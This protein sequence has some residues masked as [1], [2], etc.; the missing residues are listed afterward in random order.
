MQ[1]RERDEAPEASE[2]VWLSLLT[3]FYRLLDS[4]D[5]ESLSA[6]MADEFLWRRQGIDLRSRFDIR[7]ALS[8]RRHDSHLFHIL[9][10]VVFETVDPVRVRYTG[11][12][13]VLRAQADRPDAIRVAPSG[14]QS[15][16][17]CEGELGLRD[18]CWR[19]AAMDAG[20]PRL[21]INLEETIR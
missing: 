13:V 18:G 7:A 14:A 11:Y 12:L 16:H 4:G 20:A 21:L 5:V 10:S 3:R 15:L 2:S 1:V 9:S 19:V 8:Q 6:L 17:L